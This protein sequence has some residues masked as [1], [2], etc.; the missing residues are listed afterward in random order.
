MVHC[1]SID[2]T[3]GILR[4]RATDK[5]WG[6][7]TRHCKYNDNAVCLYDHSTYML[8]GTVKE[9]HHATKLEVKSIELRVSKPLQTV[10]GQFLTKT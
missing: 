6:L 4:Y 8:F 1:S 10:S 9:L 7:K 2:E 5:M 3:G